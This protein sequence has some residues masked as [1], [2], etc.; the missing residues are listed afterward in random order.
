[1][2]HL[3]SYLNA[4]ITVIITASFISLLLPKGEIK[5]YVRFGAGL[6]V[7][8]CFANMITGIDAVLPDE[9]DYDAYN[10]YTQTEFN[11]QVQSTMRTMLEKEVEEKFNIND[12]KITIGDD[13]RVKSVEVADV[14]RL[15]EIEVYLGVNNID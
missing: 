13:M 4:I 9:I 10:T 3:S 15:R 11:S 2:T 1:M 6:I 12:V 8:C 5:K 14:S 7:I